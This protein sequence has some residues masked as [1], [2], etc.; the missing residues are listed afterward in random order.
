M[1]LIDRRHREKGIGWHQPT[2]L[3][4]YPENMDMLVDM[5]LESQGAAR[6]H[7]VFL[8]DRMVRAFERYEERVDAVLWREIEGVLRREGAARDVAKREASVLLDQMADERDIYFDVLLTL[9]GEGAGHWDGSWDSYMSERQADD[10]TTGLRQGLSE[11]ADDTGGG[12]LNEAIS[13]AVDESNL[14]G[15]RSG[16]GFRISGD[17]NNAA[18]ARGRVDPWLRRGRKR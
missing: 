18:V 8:T 14:F 4:M 12:A 1:T 13:E 2:V 10:L 9:R 17:R 6:G 11:F 15:L 7:E 5:E 3:K 16:R